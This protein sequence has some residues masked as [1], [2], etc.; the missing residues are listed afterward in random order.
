M[1]GDEL[2]SDGT[3]GDTDGYTT[4]VN[5]SDTDAD[6]LGDGWEVTYGFNPT[7]ANAPS[8]DSDGDGLTDKQEFSSG[9]NPLSADTDGDGMPDLFEFNN[10]LNLAYNDASLDKDSDALS[11]LEE[12]QFGTQANYFDSDGDLLGDGWEVNQGLNPLSPDGIDGM[13]GDADGYGLNNFQEQSYRTNPS[14][15]DT[16]ND[17]IAD[18]YDSDGDGVGDGAEVTQG[19]IPNDASDGGVPPTGDEMLKVKIIIGD[20]SGSQS[21]RWSVAVTDL[22]TNSVILNHQSPTFGELSDDQGSIFNQFRRDRSYEI[23][24]SHI[25]TDPGNDDP[26]FYPD[27]D[28]ALEISVE[29]EN[30]LFVDVTDS[31]MTEPHFLV[32]DPWDPSLKEISNTVKLLVDRYE[33]EFPWEGHPDRTQQYQEQIAN[34]RVLLLKVEFETFAD[35]ETRE[36]GGNRSPNWKAHTL[37]LNT[38]Q[39]EETHYGDY[40]KCVAHIWSN[41]PL[42]LAKYLSD[43]ESNQEVFENPDVLNWRVDGQLQTSFELNLGERPDPNLVTKFE[44]EVLVKENS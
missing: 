20:P 35:D 37:N 30:G 43:Y 5:N 4:E 22:T 1:D 27:Y 32:L 18:G 14:P 10:G 26:E 38:K 3:Y 31:S 28:W 25:A 7:S 21:E 15:E 33:L 17:G 19:S 39:D 40:K 34:K 6:E 9:G 24:L 12:Y 16:N 41:Q 8:T 36:I 44:I 23:K 29:D 13:H 11:N 42:N 2:F